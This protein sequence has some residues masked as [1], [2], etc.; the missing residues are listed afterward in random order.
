MGHIFFIAPTPD[1]N[2]D[3][4]SEWTLFWLL[5]HNLVPD[6][7]IYNCHTVRQALAAIEAPL[8]IGEPPALVVIDHSTPPREEIIKFA[9]NLRNCIPES[10]ILE[11]V[12]NDMPL[13][14]AKEN[15]FWVRKPVC[16]EDWIAVLDHVFFR[17][18]TPQWSASEK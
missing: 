4:I 12:P 2:L 5:E 11:I 3:E 16:K 15:A 18:G 1:T 14:A 7:A 6:T 10:W 8:S 9:D 13:P 17:A